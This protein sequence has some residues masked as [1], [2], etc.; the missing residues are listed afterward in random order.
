MVHSWTDYKA[1]FGMIVVS[2]HPGDDSGDDSKADVSRRATCSM[3]SYAVSQRLAQPSLG[4]RKMPS[5]H[6]SSVGYLGTSCRAPEPRK[7]CG[8]LVV[9]WGV[10]QR[11]RESAFWVETL[12][13]SGVGTPASPPSL[14]VDPQYSMATNNRGVVLLELCLPSLS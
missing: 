13:R 11:R 2:R 1:E 8:C 6:L 14:L 3:F 4:A 12:L 5:H 7:Q 10:P 9:S